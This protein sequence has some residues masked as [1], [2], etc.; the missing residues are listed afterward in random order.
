LAESID[1]LISRADEIGGGASEED[2]ERFARET[3]LTPPPTF[4][5]FLLR[6][7]WA[8]VGA[9][10]YFGLG[11]RVPRYLDLKVVVQEERER[12]QRGLPPGLLPIRTD[13]GGNF[14][15]LD[16]NR[17]VGDEAPVVFVEHGRPD[18]PTSLVGS[19]YSDWLIRD[20]QSRTIPT[21]TKNGS[22][23][24][25]A[26]P[27]PVHNESSSAKVARCS[28][29]MTTTT[30]SF[31]SIEGQRQV[32]FEYADQPEEDPQSLLVVVPRV[33]TK[34]DVLDVLR[35]GLAVPFWFG[36]NWDALN[37]GLQDLSWVRVPNVV[38]FHVAVPELPIAELKTYLE[39][40]SL[41][42]AAPSAQERSLRVVFPPG[43]EP[44]IQTVSESAP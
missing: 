16:T 30:H 32:S 27:M 15:A 24:P 4:R 17:I 12:F 3:G 36:H 21:T 44:I 7:G 10:E 8:S 23:P 28:L 14:Y 43:A 33:R 26:F 41:A 19:G 29:P 34:T 1:L 39:I 22:C 25:R 5:E 2:V 40:L 6:V 18:A 11:Q 37:E 42:T 35:D 13:G 38:L 31:Q 20:P 9:N